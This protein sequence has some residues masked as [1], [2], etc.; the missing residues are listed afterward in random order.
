MTSPVVRY[1][2]TSDELPLLV[3]V[4]K[5]GSGRLILRENSLRKLP[6]KA[7]LGRGGRIMVLVTGVP[8]LTRWFSAIRILA[9]I[10]S[11]RSPVALEAESVIR[12]H[13]AMAHQH[14]RHSSILWLVPVCV[15]SLRTAHTGDGPAALSGHSL[16]PFWTAHEPTHLLL[17]RTRL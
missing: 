14:R 5:G 1:S 17:Q 10:G 13:R 6:K 15:L 9:L 11:P 8:P 4:Q 2:P 3:S 12:A 7:F 16:V